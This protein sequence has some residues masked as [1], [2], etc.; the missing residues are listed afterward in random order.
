M[1]KKNVLRYGAILGSFLVVVYLISNLFCSDKKND[2]LLDELKGL[3]EYQLEN[4]RDER[5]LRIE[6]LQNMLANDDSWKNNHELGLLYLEMENYPMAI[7]YLTRAY[8]IAKKNNEKNEMYDS[9]TNLSIAY[10]G[11]KD[12]PKALSLLER[13]KK[14]D[15]M[16]AKAYNKTGNIY[17]IKKKPEK[18]EIEYKTA[19]KVEKTNPESYM[20]LAKQQ[21]KKGNKKEAIAYLK[22]GVENNPEKFQSYENLGD[23]YAVAGDTENA[24][25]S[26][27]T[28]A[29]KKDATAGDKARIYNK[30]SRL[31]EKSG[32]QEKAREY[33][34]KAHSLDPSNAQVLERKGD[35]EYRKGNKK[36]ALDYYKKSLAA[37]SRN[38]GLKKKYSRVYNEYATALEAKRKKRIQEL[39]EGNGGSGVSGDGN[40]SGGSG[41]SGDGNGTGNGNG[42]EKNSAA[43]KSANS[44][45]NSGKGDDGSSSATSDKNNKSSES[46][47]VDNDSKNETSGNGGDKADFQNEISRGKEAFGKKDYYDAEKYFRN[48]LKSNPES[49]EASYLLGRALEMK[50]DDAGAEK[51]FQ[52]AVRKNPKDEKTYYYLGKLYFRQKKYNEAVNSFD[53]AVRLKPDNYAA[54][55]S[56]GLA[57]DALKKYSPAVSSY[58]KALS[59]KP[60]LYEAKYNLGISHKKNGQYADA[61]K[62]FQELSKERSDANVFNQMGETYLLQKNYPS[63]LALFRKAL[64]KDSSNGRTHYN[65]GIVYGKMNDPGNA[66][67]SLQKIS[68]PQDAGVFYELG[69]NYEKLKNFPEARENYQKAVQMNPN[70]FKAHLSLGNVYKSENS[71]R[72][73][74]E[75]Y[76]KAHRINSGSFEINYNLANLYYGMEKYEEADKY[77]QACL[78]SDPANSDVRLGYAQNL[79][80]A[81]KPAAAEIQYKAVLARNPKDAVAM[82]KL[83]YLYYRNLK[84]NEKAKEMFQ[85]LVQSFPSHPKK[86]EYQNI[87]QYLEKSK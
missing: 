33:L 44:K 7:K 28:A 5:L 63:S 67:S 69:K 37:N 35:M 73:A 13:A 26:Y 3:K 65:M 46:G 18:A 50:N 25:K 30:M 8:D 32:N 17:D 40:G 82:D 10:S 6:N 23:G 56:R 55:Y 85:R 79:V 2:N 70:Y 43:D 80:K 60:D 68:D 16:K 45:S 29:D 66:I 1:D 74:E 83:A 24:L 59:I 58:Q 11:M 15:S 86:S 51:A 75:A 77:F 54:F 22:K 78:V 41:N 72:E 38:P 27:S 12:Y 61:L 36:A 39:E 14:I 49:A 76:L 20:N 62:V 52:D 9:L 87:I 81:G 71:T 84:N 64:E 53:H 21:L 57:Y 48:A 47:R 42:T 34:D 4:I 31:Y 19:Q